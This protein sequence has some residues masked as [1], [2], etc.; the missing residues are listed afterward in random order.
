MKV[1]LFGILVGS[2]AVAVWIFRGS[3]SAT[4]RPEIRSISTNNLRTESTV[5]IPVEVIATGSAP[6]WSYIEVA[7][8]A[9]PKPRLLD[10]SH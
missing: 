6:E 4:S 3:D 5:R 9:L 2:P 1:L 8:Q 7:S 10:G